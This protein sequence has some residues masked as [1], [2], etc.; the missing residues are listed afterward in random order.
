M[1]ITH[2]A[3]S[4][5]PELAMHVPKSA[6]TVTVGGDE[7]EQQ[8][9]K[10]EGKEPEDNEAT[11]EP[12]AEE[13]NED[14]ERRKEEEAATRIQ[15]VFRGHHAR[16]SMKETDTSATKQEDNE[17]TKEELEAEFREDDK[18]LCHAATKIQATFRGHMS[19]KVDQ[20]ASAAKDLMDSAA[21]KIEEKAQHIQQCENWLHSAEQAN[22]S[23]LTDA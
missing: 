5:R 23:Q 11:E 13:V 19:R 12:K 14:E 20:A 16:K 17:P 10:E 8:Q 1:I 6:E 9:Q 21:E 15:A 7:E 3:A 2:R 18:E 22:Y 4:N